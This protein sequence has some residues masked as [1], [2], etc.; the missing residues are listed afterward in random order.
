VDLPEQALINIPGSLGLLPLAHEAQAKTFIFF[1][2]VIEYGRFNIPVSE[3]DAAEPENLYGITK[4]AVMKISEKVC[5][6]YGMRFCGV[7]PFWI[8]GPGDSE[9]RMIPSL[10]EQLL[11][12]KRPSLTPG[13][14]L[15][16]FLYIDDATDALIRLAENPKAEGIFNL[17]SGKAVQLKSVMEKVR[18]LIDPS[19]ELGLGDIPY[20][21]DQIMHLQ[22]NI[23]RLEQ[24]AD[25][26]PAVELEEGLR[27]TVAWHVAQRRS[28]S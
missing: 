27:R 26:K 20:A 19:L 15:W 9:L 18:D 1:G 12:R 23:H 13:E 11:N 7:R 6:A 17:A 8:Y 4:L 28:A 24:A 3:E 16:D 10:I 22:G 2:S 21:P 14:Q 25:W 5:T